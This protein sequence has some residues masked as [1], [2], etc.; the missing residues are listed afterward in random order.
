MT[1]AESIRRALDRKPAEWKL[2]TCL[3][4]LDDAVQ[5]L[6]STNASDEDKELARKAHREALHQSLSLA[7][8]GRHWVEAERR[9]LQD[10]LIDLVKRADRNDVGALTRATQERLQFLAKAEAVC[11]LE[12]D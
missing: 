10:Y 3:R 7:D 1:P 4:L 11:G 8:R 5:I 6:D 12:S 2:S 9:R